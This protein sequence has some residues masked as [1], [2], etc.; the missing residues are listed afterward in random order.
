[1]VN[2]SNIPRS[3]EPMVAESTHLYPGVKR[4]VRPRILMYSLDR[5]SN[6]PQSPPVHEL[7]GGSVVA[8]LMPPKPPKLVHWF[9]LKRDWMRAVTSMYFEG[10]EATRK[11]ISVPCP[12]SP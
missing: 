10:R 9:W 5:G 1:M 12:L 3:V 8:G 4:A 11:L 2:A 7:G 6:S